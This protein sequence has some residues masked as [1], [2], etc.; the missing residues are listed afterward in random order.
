MIQMK[1]KLLGLKINIEK[2]GEKMGVLSKT[3]G[4]TPQEIAQETEYQNSLIL[5]ELIGL[6][7]QISELQRKID[8]DYESN[9]AKMNEK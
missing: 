1:S 3:S 6:I 7:D 4:K 9:F 8:L 5:Q 2:H